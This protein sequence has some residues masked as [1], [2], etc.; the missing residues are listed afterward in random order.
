VGKVL[1]VIAVGAA[2]AGGVSQL[3]AGGTTRSDA[4]LVVVVDGAVSGDGQPEHAPE[5]WTVDH[6]G[7][8]RYS[9]HFGGAPASFDV[10]AWDDIADVTQ[11]PAGD[12]VVLAFQRKGE[13]IDTRFTFR[14]ELDE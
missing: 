11:T 5:G 7:P 14:A 6:P 9:I 4:P 12:G 10:V 13:P 8:G 1:G 3:P 2:L